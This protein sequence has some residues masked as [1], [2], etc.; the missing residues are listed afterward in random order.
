MIDYYL[1]QRYDGR[2]W[3]TVNETRD[4]L[5]ALDLFDA[6]QSITRGRCRKVKRSKVIK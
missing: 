2:R 6:W 4:R 3:I 5:Q 1:I